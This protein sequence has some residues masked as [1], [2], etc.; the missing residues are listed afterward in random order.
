MMM[1]IMILG[2]SAQV[3]SAQSQTS[4]GSI[5]GTVY[6]DSNGNGQCPDEGEPTHPGVPIE[7][8]SDDG[9]W[10]T[11]LQ[12]GENG[13]YGLVAAGYGTWSVSA[14]PNANDFVV[15]SEPTLNVFIGS[16]EP[17]A[18]NINFCIR[19]TNASAVTIISTSTILPAAGEAAN[20]TPFTVGLLSGLALIGLGGVLFT[21][22]QSL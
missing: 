1:A 4:N 15:T 8:I 20:N 19:E 14:R 6:I 7:F 17:L 12:T 9:E 13:T 22:K 21:K 10:S 2:I 18:L 11:Y 3:I 5:R 16:E